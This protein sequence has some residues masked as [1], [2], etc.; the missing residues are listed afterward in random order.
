MEIKIFFFLFLA[1]KDKD[2][3]Q[4]TSTSDSTS[5][6]NEHPLSFGGVNPVVLESFENDLLHSVE[7]SGAKPKKGSQQS[8]ISSSK[9]N[10]SQ[11]S[12]SQSRSERGE[13]SS[14]NKK[15]QPNDKAENDAVDP[16]VNLTSKL[17][18]LLESS[19]TSKKSTKTK[20]KTITTVKRDLRSDHKYD[21]FLYDGKSTR[22]FSIEVFINWYNEN[23][24]YYEQKLDT[25]LSDFSIPKENR[26][27]GNDRLS[28]AYL[29][30]DPRKFSDSRKMVWTDFIESVFYI[31]KGKNKRAHNHTQEAE[32]YWQS[33]DECVKAK[34]R[35]IHDI[36]R[37]KKPV[38]ILMIFQ[39]VVAEDACTREACMIDAIG[40]NKLCNEISGSYYGTASTLTVREKRELGATLLVKARLDLMK[41][42]AERVYPKTWNLSAF[43]KDEVKNNDVY[44]YDWL[45]F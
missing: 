25:I 19:S 11:E 22:I 45:H 7:K 3:K 16:V 37:T 9:Q 6:L 28:Y 43:A 33:G 40:K 39:N 15:K 1:S 44:D 23:P 38:L 29:L 36:W 10:E 34:V 32:K 26:V 31:G 18:A 13:D 14:S 27:G 42:G 35:R 24:S 30:L 2:S 5:D 17:D 8:D 4:I 12:K 20:S 41:L 21:D